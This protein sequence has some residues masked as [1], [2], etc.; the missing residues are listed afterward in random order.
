MELSAPSNFYARV[1]KKMRHAGG[2]DA[3]MLVGFSFLRRL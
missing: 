1:I 2:H 3:D